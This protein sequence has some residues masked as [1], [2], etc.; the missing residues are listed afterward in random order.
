MPPTN[1]NDVGWG[2]TGW[3]ESRSDNAFG[4]A[5]ASLQLWRI[6]AAPWS[7]T[8]TAASAQLRPSGSLDAGLRKVVL[9]RFLG[10][11]SRQMSLRRRI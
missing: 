11:T 9:Q 8:A 4:P 3:I 5:P 2:T 1:D 6:V 10:S 7:T